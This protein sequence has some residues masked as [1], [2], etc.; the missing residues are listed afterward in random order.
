MKQIT[1]IGED[2]S[3][4]MAEISS[5]LAEGGIN[6][7]TLDAETIQEWTV[8][9]LTVDRYDDAIRVLQQNPDLRIITDDAILLR[10]EDRPGA[11][12]K[13]AKR[14]KDANINMR[15]V[16]I[17]RRDGQDALVA[18]ST[19]RSSAALELVKDSLVS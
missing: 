5:A 9:I 16:R 13:I 2:R 17:I 15:S 6:I 8:M 10:L 7:E 3:G 1:I 14:F 18:I 11:L 12:A 19:E 4:M